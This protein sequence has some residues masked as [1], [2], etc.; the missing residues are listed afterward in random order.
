MWRVPAADQSSGKPPRAEYH[1]GKDNV[2]TIMVFLS[3]LN[4][5]TAVYRLA[6]DG[7]SSGEVAAACGWFVA[8]IAYLQI[9]FIHE[10]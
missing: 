6:I 9:K 7:L 8:L 5:A 1:Q 3:A 2:T 10:R 4:L